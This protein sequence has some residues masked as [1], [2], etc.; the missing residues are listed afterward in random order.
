MAKRTPPAAS[1]QYG[2]FDPDLTDPSTVVTI[3]RRALVARSGLG[4]AVSA[5]GDRITIASPA[6]RLGQRD[7]MTEAET[8]RLASLLDL[9]RPTPLLG[10]SFGPDRYLEYVDRA[11]G[12]APRAPGETDA[13]S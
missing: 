13:A 9:G 5:A 2:L 8:R 12:R 6:P 3:V 4:W 7:R 10:V 11:Q 1:E